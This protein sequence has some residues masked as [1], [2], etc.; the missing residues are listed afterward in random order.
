M[1]TLRFEHRSLVKHLKYKSIVALVMGYD[2]GGW[3]R[4]GRRQL[5]ERLW[6]TS[7]VV[8]AK[9]VRRHAAML[10]GVAPNL[11]KAQRCMCLEVE[12][13]L[14]VEAACNVRGGW[15]GWCVMS[16]ECGKVG[17]HGR[18][19]EAG[20]M[21]NAFSFGSLSLFQ[22]WFEIY[23]FLFSPLIDFAIGNF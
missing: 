11:L 13:D 22:I 5:H 8:G 3:W 17:E 18:R 9:V 15:W 21:R 12:S 7:G 16:M 2:E 19:R 23:F 10:V 20:L 4:L 1:K 14:E 6:M